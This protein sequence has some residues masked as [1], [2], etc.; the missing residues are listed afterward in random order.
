MDKGQL[1]SVVFIDLAKAFDTV[2]RDILLSK[3]QINGVDSMS[4]NWFKS[5]LFYRKQ[6]CNVNGLVRLERSLLCG[7]PQGSNLGP[8]LFQV[9]I[10][11]DCN[12]AETCREKTRPIGCQT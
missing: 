2:D 8:L 3:L 9:Y 4:L 10:T 11:V 1:N 7:V 5:Y 6:N 12:Q